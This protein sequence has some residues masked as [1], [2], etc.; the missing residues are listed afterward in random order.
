MSKQEFLKALSVR[1]SALPQIDPDKH[2]Q[3][4]EEMI[5][6][7][8][9]DGMS[10]ED[11]V[12]DVGSIDKICNEI[13]DNIPFYRIAAHKI[14]QSGKMSG[15]K[16]AVLA[17][18]A[19]IWAPVLISLIATA[20]A[21]YVSLLAS[22]WSVVASV[23]AVFVST[24]VAAVAGVILF[25]LN[26]FVGSFAHGFTLLSFGLASAGVA[27]FSYYGSIYTTKGAVKLTRST[28]RWIK[29]MFVKR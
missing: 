3:F 29:N 9:E 19:I 14:K 26:I 27:I 15:G 18:T 1:L 20:F 24:A 12:A 28:L 23:W 10:E 2:I 7:R 25:P 4:Y 17:S 6:D 13:I 16:I 22:L 21:I 11:A 5:N 8:I